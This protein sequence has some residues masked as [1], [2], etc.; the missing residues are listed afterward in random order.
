MTYRP[1]GLSWDDAP[2][3]LSFVYAEERPAGRH[4]F[5]RVAGDHF[6]FEDG[7]PGRFWGTCFNSGANFPR[8]SE[9]DRIA[10]RLEKFGV[11][12]V[13]TH[14]MDSEWA[15]PNIFEVNRAVPRDDTRHLD[16]TSLDRLDYLFHCLKEHGI[17]VYLDLLTYRQF[18]AADGARTA[19]GLPAAAKP[20]L[21]FDNRLIA[22]Q[23][24]FNEQLWSHV[25]PYTGLA[26]RD[27][28]AIVLTELINESDFLSNPVQLEPYR[29]EL[30][31]RFLSWSRASG[32]A[33]TR[34]ASRF[35]QADPGNDGVLQSYPG[36][37][38]PGAD[39]AP[40]IGW[41]PDPGGG[42]Q[43][44]PQPHDP[45]EPGTNRFLR[46]ALVLELPFLGELGHSPG[47]DGA[48][49]AE[50]FRKWGLPAAN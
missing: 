23:K 47:P 10:E 14:Q 25:N 24:E 35:R 44:V 48:R 5:L 6:E 29:S 50:R 40:A 1:F 43:L 41:R 36:Q 8:H 3:D 20:Y 31:D 11:N 46:H 32:R 30:E 4:G 34:N 15:T 12:L 37:L 33:T 18:L 26:Y 13:R 49:K 17:Y 28:P 38:L 2:I 45:G 27:E 21:Y 9:S 19:T 7:T 42:H 22:L 39:P 16:P